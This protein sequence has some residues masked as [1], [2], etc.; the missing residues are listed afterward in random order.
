MIELKG[1]FSFIGDIRG[2]GLLLGI[3]FV[4][5]AATK[6][7]FPRKAMV[8]QKII[9]L[10]KEKGLLVYPA[11]AGIDGVNGDAIIIAPPLTITKDE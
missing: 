2:K 7:P 1:Q 9:A 5:D 6:T 10:A 8:T 11:G 4:E 3:E